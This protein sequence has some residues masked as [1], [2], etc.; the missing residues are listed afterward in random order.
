MDV[1][2][3][4]K[5]NGLTLK[6]SFV[7]PRAVGTN[8]QIGFSFKF[9]LIASTNLVYVLPLEKKSS[10]RTSWDIAR[11]ERHI[12]QDITEDRKKAIVTLP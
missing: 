2:D 6:L 1:P 5:G 4:H 11:N 3:R 10:A 8:I 12:T 9:F 7:Q